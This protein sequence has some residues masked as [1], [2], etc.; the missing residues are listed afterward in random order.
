MWLCL[1]YC[2]FKCAYLPSPV[3]AC[4]DLPHSH[5]LTPVCICPHL[6]RLAHTCPCLLTPAL[7]FPRPYLP[8]P[9]HICSHLFLFTPAHACPY[10]PSPA[11]TCPHLTSPALTCPCP[12]QSKPHP[13]HVIQDHFL[14]SSHTGLIVLPISKAPIPISLLA[15]C[16]LP[17]A[18][19]EDDSLCARV[20][21]LSYNEYF[22]LSCPGLSWSDMGKQWMS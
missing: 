10:L 13:S 6:S 5:W 9:V 18:S 2:V 22:P 19:F 12:Q 3:D 21:S 8:V 14:F 20:R 16:Q 4:S 7:T 11:L 1:A 15:S 17:P